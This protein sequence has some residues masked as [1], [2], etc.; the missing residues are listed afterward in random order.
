MAVTTVATGLAQGGTYPVGSRHLARTKVGGVEWF[1][2]AQADGVRLS[3]STDGGVTFAQQLVLPWSS[4]TNFRTPEVSIRLDEDDYLHLVYTDR[5]NNYVCYRLGTPSADRLNYTF[6]APFVAIA[7][8]QANQVS[9]CVVGMRDGD[10]RVAFV[11]C[12]YWS[13][14]WSRGYAQMIRVTTTPAGVVS[15]AGKQDWYFNE[16]STPPPVALEFSHTGDG[17]TPSGATPTVLAITGGTI[18]AGAGT[19]LTV[20]R[21][22]RGAPGA[23]TYQGATV[24]E[25][26]LGI[27][28][29]LL[30]LAFDGTRFVA[31]VNHNNGSSPYTPY[32]RLY[33]I[34]V[35]GSV[36]RRVNVPRA[37]VQAPDYGAV[38]CDP[39]G[40]VWL[41]SRLSN[42]TGAP[43]VRR[44]W[45]RASATWET[46]VVVQATTN[47]SAPPFVSPVPGITNGRTPYVWTN[48]PAPFT[49]SRDALV[50]NAAPGAPTLTAP[51]VGEVIDRAAKTRFAFPL[52]DPDAGDTQS[53]YRLRYRL[54]GAATWTERYEVT[55]VQ[56][57]DA[58]A[59]TFAVGDHEW[60]V[61]STDAQGVESLEWSA[62][63][64]FTAGD[65]PLAP[66]FLNP[67]N[68]ATIPS[69][70][71]TA[72]VSSPRLDAL[73]WRVLGDLNGQ[74]DPTVVLNVGATIED[75]TA[76]SFTAT[77]LPN[78]TVAHLQA[79]QRDR[80]LW[81][82][83]ADSRNPVSYTPPAVPLV[84]ITPEPAQGRVLVAITNPART[85]DQPAVVSHDVLVDDGAGWQRRA[86]NLQ[87]GATWPYWRAVDGVDYSTRI[88]VVAI[89]AN[90]TTS[91]SS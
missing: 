55:P 44:R 41:I 79:R 5:A 34:T 77:G 9:P 4:T 48:G 87:P 53:A 70:R 40:N 69:D 85:G 56:W 18:G 76:R 28:G 46:D 21:W 88:R 78:S 6:S 82:P 81:S 45:L 32:F 37:D 3:R 74:P 7:E 1:A 14:A 13:S 51:A 57:W 54:V 72:T 84:A 38:A 64:Y 49:V 86:T 58:P 52:N 33:D 2:S 15:T 8:Y 91:T 42:A 66:T 29:S 50:F 25:S 67:A 26:T 60:G 11:A 20:G 65:A 63:S 75:P 23:W 83:W 19:G 27:D 62:S 36:S 10:N 43:L 59:G 17:V 90:G 22:T 73:D 89:A 68:G 16:K 12:G 61:K 30:S 80:G 47:T 31:A 71:V 35:T 39:A 24:P